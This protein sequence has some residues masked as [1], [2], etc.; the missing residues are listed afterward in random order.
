MYLNTVIVHIYVK[1]KWGSSH[2]GAHRSLARVSVRV[3]HTILREVF[4]QSRASD[5]WGHLVVRAIG[6]PL[7]IKSCSLLNLGLIKNVSLN[8]SFL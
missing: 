6:G 4:G 7:F 2:A 8:L 3:C 1:R 5:R